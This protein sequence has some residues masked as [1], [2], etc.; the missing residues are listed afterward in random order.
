MF[1]YKEAILLARN[2]LYISCVIYRTI[3]AI[4]YLLVYAVS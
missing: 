1:H 3:Y 2:F 4:G